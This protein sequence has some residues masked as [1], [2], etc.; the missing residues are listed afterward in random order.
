[1]S[2]ED[3][4]FIDLR[5]QY[6]QLKSNIDKRIQL[7]L[8]HGQYIMGP[9]V[10]ELEVSLARFIGVKNVITCANGTDAL[11]LSL[12]ALGIGPGDAVF[13]T[14]FTFFATAEVI[15][16]AGAT[17]VFVD[18]DEH[19][20][21]ICPTK[22][23]AK[24]R[25]VL[26]QGV[27]HPKA[28][29]S[30]DLFGLPA[31]YRSLEPMARKYNLK[32]IEDAAQ[33]FGGEI[34]GRKAG[35]FGDVATT[36][37]FPA[38]PLGCYGDGGAIFTNNN[39]LASI[40]RSYRVHG[41]GN[42]KYDN[43]RIGLNSRLDT[44]Q[45]AVLLAKLEAFPE[46]L[47]RRNAVAEKYSRDLPEFC[48]RP[49]VPPTFSSAWAQYTVRSDRRDWIIEQ[50]ALNN[51]PAMVYYKKCMHQQTAFNHLDIEISDLSIAEKTSQEVVSFPMH[52]YLSESDQDAINKSL[53][54]FN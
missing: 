20:F 17:P 12:M 43:V 34:D 48:C 24:I 9:E 21:N 8:D 22:L 25:Q 45:A 14:T 5:S 26:S 28:I 10:M 42:D 2:R 49:V 33:G 40:I 53:L 13:T 36:S 4:Q 27:L 51:I 39:D 50:L 23:E 6:L 38:K 41:K 19:T 54:G 30:V 1:M 32:L 44:I 18:I 35:S 7:V 52:P 46:E 37:F 16:L 11:Q 3:I 29:I 15:A 31:D 47:Q